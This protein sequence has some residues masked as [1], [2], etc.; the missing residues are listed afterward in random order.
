MNSYASIMLLTGM[1]LLGLAGEVGVEPSTARDVTASSV[2]EVAWY[3]RASTFPKP[4]R[5]PTSPSA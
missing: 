3:W 5:T 1:A 4:R 2:S